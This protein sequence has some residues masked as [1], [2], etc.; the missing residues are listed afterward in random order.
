MLKEP[1]WTA[2]S[3]LLEL[4]LYQRNHQDPKNPQEKRLDKKRTNQELP[5]E[6]TGP[7]D[8]KVTDPKENAFKETDKTDLKELELQEL[9]EIDLK[10]TDQDLRERIENNQVMSRESTSPDI[11]MK[12][13]FTLEI[14]V[15]RLPK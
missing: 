4:S 7:Q 3:R 14:L 12:T 10:E 11:T 8:L 1:T 13:Q 5:E 9:K 6:V 2:K 15:S